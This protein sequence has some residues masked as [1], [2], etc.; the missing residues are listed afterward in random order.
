MMRA[1][2]VMTGE[3]TEKKGLMPALFCA[4]KYL[5]RMSA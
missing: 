2:Q 1:R 5:N 4:K 3:F